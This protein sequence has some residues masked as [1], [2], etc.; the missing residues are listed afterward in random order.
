[1]QNHSEWND[2][3]ASIWHPSCHSRL[4][5]L[6]L[7]P[8][9]SAGVFFTVSSYVSRPLGLGLRAVHWWKLFLSHTSPACRTSLLPDSA[10]FCLVIMKNYIDKHRKHLQTHDLQV[11]KK[12][13]FLNW[14]VFPFG[15][16]M[17]QPYQHLISLNR[18]LEHNTFSVIIAELLSSDKKMYF[19]FSSKFHELWLLTDLLHSSV[20][21]K[22]TAN[23]WVT[24]WADIKIA[25]C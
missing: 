15:N 24:V 2:K 13:K 9:L 16:A 11:L 8:S 20:N 19:P 18:A 6:S 1:M 10:L 4:M 3:V 7:C 21:A 17:Y 14:N 5:L 22:F 23:E 12:N 25:K